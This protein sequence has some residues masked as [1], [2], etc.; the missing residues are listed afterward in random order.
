LKPRQWKLAFLNSKLGF[1]ARLERQQA[2]SSTE[3]S[4]SSGPLRHYWDDVEWSIYPVSGQRKHFL[5]YSR[6]DLYE[7]WFEEL[8]SDYKKLL[9]GYETVSVWPRCLDVTFIRLTKDS[10]KNIGDFDVVFLPRVVYNVRGQASPPCTDPRC[11][12]ADN[13]NLQPELWFSR[14]RDGISRRQGGSR[15]WGS[16]RKTWT[17]TAVEKAAS[18]RK[19][20]AAMDGSVAGLTFTQETRVYATDRQIFFKYNQNIL[21]YCFSCTPWPWHIDTLMI[22]Q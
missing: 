4:L 9:T 17:S 8:K 5:A 16:F 7:G 13:F 12:F 6:A 2:C 20:A 14:R 22:Y 15:G 11:S 3:Q 18:G 1:L 10:S 19:K 21:F